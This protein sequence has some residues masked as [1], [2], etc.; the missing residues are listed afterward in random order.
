MSYV[1]VSQL[2][3]DGGKQK[4]GLQSMERNIRGHELPTLHANRDPLLSL[5][6]LSR[7]SRSPVDRCF[8]HPA[9]GYQGSQTTPVR[10]KFRNCEELLNGST[11][12]R[13]VVAATLRRGYGTEGFENDVGHPLASANVTANN[14]CK[15]ARIKQ[16]VGRDLH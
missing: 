3:G 14:G 16:G 10:F 13:K 9:R 5:R 15:G 11:H 6:R 2:R 12:K 8:L 1:T 4:A 7:S